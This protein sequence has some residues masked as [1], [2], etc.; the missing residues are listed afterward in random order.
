[1]WADP[2]GGTEE[3]MTEKQDG[4]A[5]ISDA[6]DAVYAEKAM[7]QVPDEPIPTGRRVPDGELVMLNDA[8]QAVIAAQGELQGAQ[9]VFNTLI[10][11]L[12]QR[13]CKSPREIIGTDGRVLLMSDEQF[14]QAQRQQQGG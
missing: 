7:N 4:K 9:R 2:F 5:A 1:M 3:I 11:T 12:S 13:H 6:I 14:A 10:T 8:R